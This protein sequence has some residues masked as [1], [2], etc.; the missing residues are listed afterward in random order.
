MSVSTDRSAGHRP[1]Y[2]IDADAS[3]HD[4]LNDAT[5]WLQSSR[6]ITE[7]LADLLHQAESVNCLR[8]ALGLEAIGAL[9][10]AGVRCATEAHARLC[11]EE[12]QEGEG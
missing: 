6:G 5:E 11:W 3:V 2:S 4:L 12:A 1:S 7:L 8:M 9:T 10:Q